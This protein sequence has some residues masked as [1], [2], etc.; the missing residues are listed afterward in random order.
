MSYGD[1][2]DYHG[3]PGQTRTRLPEGD[4]GYGA[5][6]RPVRASRSLITVVG[7]VVLLV[8]AIAFAN[9]GGGSHDSASAGGDR[10]GAGG[11]AAADPT[12]PSGVTPVKGTANTATGIPSGFADDQQGAASA[13]A[14]Y[15]VAL[16]SSG[17]FHADTRHAILDTLYTPSAAAKLTGSLDAAY[18]TDFLSQLG[19]DAHGDAPQG[20]T[21][22]S[23]T[24]PVGTK[25]ESY[26]T[27]AAKVSVWYTGL[28][29]MA[30]TDSKNPVTTTWKTGTFDLRWTAG[31]WKATAYTQKNGP[32]PVP[33]DD[34]AS[35]SDQIS[36]AVEQF[37]G[38]TYAR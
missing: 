3:D 8:A 7:V 25:V 34:A 35:T 37:G 36:K 30:G 15:A 29:G 32:A 38:F 26:S 28:I 27:G 11:G 22:V 16:G 12:A 24:I 33:G 20:S 4:D 2:H 21:F 19:L 18:S 1:E 6:R 10:P 9:R 23:R 5:P 17:M 31:T 14:N 13:A